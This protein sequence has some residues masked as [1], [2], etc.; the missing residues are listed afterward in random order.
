LTVRDHVLLTGGT[1]LLGS[2][3][4]RDLLLEGR[5]VALLVRDDRKRSAAERVAGLL[6][7]W[8]AMLGKRLP[9]PIVIAGDLLRPGC[10]IAPARD[11]FLRRHA[12]A[13]AAAHRRLAPPPRA[14]PC[15]SGCW[16]ICVRAMR[17]CSRW[18]AA[19]RCLA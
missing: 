12:A 11:V 7:R 3:L 4:L 8:E 1:G 10:G 9:E 19:C 2:Y 5:P 17:L 15:T 6:G 16:R 18:R 13:G 14:P